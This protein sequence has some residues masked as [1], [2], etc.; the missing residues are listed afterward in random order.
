MARAREL[1]AYLDNFQ[2]DMET[3]TTSEGRRQVCRI[4]HH[5]PWMGNWRCHY[6]AGQ[7]RVY[8]SRIHRI[9]GRPQ[10]AFPT[11]TPEAVRLFIMANHPP[12]P[13]TSSTLATTP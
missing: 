10:W 7:Y 9:S 1:I 2:R 4:Y 8:A 3:V 11:D 5:E 6:A 13:C 12:A